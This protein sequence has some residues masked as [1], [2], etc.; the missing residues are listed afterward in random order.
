MDLADRFL[1]SFLLL[2][3]VPTFQVLHSALLV[4]EALDFHSIQI[5]LV[6]QG[7]QEDQGFL[8]ILDFLFLH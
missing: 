3:S 5:Y 2:L 4:R 1:L 6:V 7:T 8:M